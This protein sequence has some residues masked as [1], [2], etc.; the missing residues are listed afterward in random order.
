MQATYAA[1]AAPS[2]AEADAAAVAE[3]LTSKLGK[4][5]LRRFDDSIESCR[6]IA[7][8]IFKHMLQAGPDATLPMLPYAMPVLEERL[9]LDEV[10]CFCNMRKT[11]G[12]CSDLW[13]LLQAGGAGATRPH[14]ILYVSHA[15]HW[16]S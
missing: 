4:S 8:T 9:H 16:Y 6:E 14:S 3:V 10:Q 12:I 2:T 7:V 11:A 15:A 5:L 13:S 1:D